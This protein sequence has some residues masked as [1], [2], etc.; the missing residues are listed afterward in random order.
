M[1][2][3]SQFLSILPLSIRRGP[4]LWGF[5]Q[6]ARAL[7]RQ[8]RALGALPPDRLADLGLTQ[9]EAE[10]EACRPFWDAPEWWRG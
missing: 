8:R 9:R 7:S 2:F 4:G 10:N 3:A 5:V 1:S 6:R